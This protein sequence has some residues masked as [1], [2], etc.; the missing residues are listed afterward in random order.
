MEPTYAWVRLSFA[1]P[2]LLANAQPN[3]M[4]LNAPFFQREKK[5]NKTFKLFGLLL[6]LTVQPGLAETG[7]VNGGGVGDAAGAGGFVLS[8]KQA[9]MANLKIC[10]DTSAYVSGINIKK[11]RIRG[12]K[13]PNRAK[14][15]STLPDVL[16]PKDFIPLYVSEELEIT[17]H[18]ALDQVLPDAV[19]QLMTMPCDKDRTAAYQKNYGDNFIKRAIK[20]RRV[21]E[22]VT[23]FFV[24][25]CK[26]Q[27]DYNGCIE[28]LI[29]AAEP[30]PD[31]SEENIVDFARKLNEWRLK[32]RH[33]T[34]TQ[35]DVDRI[36]GKIMT[37]EW[38]L[39][40]A[41]AKEKSEAP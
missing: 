2:L 19:S 40:S 15:C 30:I 12:C 21:Y 8:P 11:S 33:I 17:N 29:Y 10:L 23:D 4:P 37:L 6:L 25:L 9:K 5:M 31:G 7:A 14:F 16:E 32:F 22:I 18:D 1:K 39:E 35:T 26:K 3:S 36:F 24:P 34:L 27:A 38:V 20:N 28:K 13:E 41:R